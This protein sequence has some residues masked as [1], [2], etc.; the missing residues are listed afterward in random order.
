MVL[1]AW[2]FGALN[3]LGGAIVLAGLAA[4]WLQR[5]DRSAS[6]CHSER[7]RNDDTDADVSRRAAVPAD[8]RRRARA[9]AGPRQAGRRRDVERAAGPHRGAAAYDAEKGVIPGSCMLIARHGKIAMFEASG[10]RDPQ[11]RV[12]MTRDAI[13][14]STR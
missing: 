9:D 14:A 13:S 3:A 10:A 6:R 1:G 11:T 12:P 7:S 4:M 2:G 8:R 5:S